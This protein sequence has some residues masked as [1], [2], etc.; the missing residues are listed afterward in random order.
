MIEINNLTGSR[1]NNKRLK[2]I[3]ESVF[4]KESVNCQK[5]KKTISVAFVGKDAI[6]ELNR[7][8]RKKNKA[9]DELS[10]RYSKDCGELVICPDLTK[11]IAR[12]LVHGILHLL[13]YD[14]EKSKKNAEEMQKKEEYYLSRLKN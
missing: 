13:G 5:V 9:T 1:I 6:K 8:Y 2:K 7:K 12:S 11:D 14:H 4:K 10:F 3:A